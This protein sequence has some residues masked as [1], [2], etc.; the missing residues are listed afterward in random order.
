[1]GDLSV[2]GLDQLDLVGVCGF[3]RLLEVHFLHVE[4]KVALDDICLDVL[5]EDVLQI[6]V[7]LGFAAYLGQLILEKRE[8]EDLLPSNAFLC[9]NGKHLLDQQL[10]LLLA[11]VV[12]EI[13]WLVLDVLQQ[14]GDILGSP[15][16]LP[17]Q[18]LVEN[19][20]HRPHV[21]FGREFLPPQDLRSRVQGSA[22]QGELLRVLRVGDL[23]TEAKIA[24]FGDP[25]LHEDVGWLDVSVDDVVVKE[26]LVA[27]DDV[28]HEHEGL[29]LADPVFLLALLEVS[30]KVDIFT[31]LQEDVEEVLVAVVAEH[32]HDEGRSQVLQVLNLVFE[33]F[34]KPGVDLADVDLL[35]CHLLACFG[36]EAVEDLAGL[37][38]AQHDGA[39]HLEVPDV[40]PLLILHYFNKLPARL[41]DKNRP[42]PVY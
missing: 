18:H 16:G 19:D 17:V 14:L 9:V 32:A 30:F 39:A 10:D 7:A 29:G 2:D 26:L 42:P 5:H 13:Q 6:L 11:L 36:V 33:L 37:P 15:R 24:E 28:A 20:S 40:L 31:V 23:P 38:L 12:P 8:P 3:H 25:L 35:G 4:P 34:L 22:Q 1:M 27:L 21:A 41:Y